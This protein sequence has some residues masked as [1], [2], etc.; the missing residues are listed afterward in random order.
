MFEMVT[1]IKRVT[2]CHAAKNVRTH[3]EDRRVVT[4]WREEQNLRVCESK[5]H[6]K[7]LCLSFC[8]F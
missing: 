1:V 7:F 5:S 3:A 4:Q 2:S 8:G 6:N